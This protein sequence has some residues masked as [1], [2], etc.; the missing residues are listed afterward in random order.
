MEGAGEI[1]DAEAGEVND[2]AVEVLKM[3]GV[4]AADRE[5]AE[6]ARSGVAGSRVATRGEPW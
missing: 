2:H 3:V 1:G 5:Q 6:V 4:A